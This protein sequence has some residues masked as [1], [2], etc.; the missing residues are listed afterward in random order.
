M[1]EY[2]PISD[3]LDNHLALLLKELLKQEKRSVMGA[4]DKRR[5]ELYRLI[6][7]REAELANEVELERLFESYLA[8]LPVD[9]LPTSN[10]QK[11]RMYGDWETD[12]RDE[13]ASWKNELAELKNRPIDKRLIFK[14]R[15]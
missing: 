12:F 13:L 3:D 15:T 14:Q 8:G 4:A 7:Q 5:N 10:L 2:S 11:Y 1:T 9:E 6:E